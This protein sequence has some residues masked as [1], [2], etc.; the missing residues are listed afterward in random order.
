MHSVYLIA[1]REVTTRLSS[2]SFIAGTLVTVA[3]LVACIIGSTFL[4][5]GDDPTAMAPEFAKQTA[6]ASDQAFNEVMQ[7]HGLVPEQI[8]A[9]VATATTD[10]LAKLQ[11]SQG[12]DASMIGYFLGIGVAVLLFVALQITGQMIAQGIV[13]EKGS[14]VVEILLGTVS[15]FQLLLGK[16]LGVGI[17]GILQ[18][19][20]I[21][22]SA[23]G[24][25]RAVSIDVLAGMNISEIAL[26]LVPCFLVAY[27]AYATLYAALASTV[28][29]Q[30]EVPQVITPVMILMMISYIGVMI[31][32]IAANSVVKFV[33][34]Y[35]PLASNISMPS[36]FASGNIQ[37]WECLVSLGVSA[38][39]LPVIVWIAS[40]I[41]SRSI[42][43]SGPKVKWVKALLAKG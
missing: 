9:E 7:K 40:R 30:E 15:S 33:L 38:L 43:Q 25:A 17:V 20:V 11:D 34:T 31:P 1:K 13:E 2:K 14:R 19:A 35:V 22:G 36:L 10:A 29:R 21:V 39:S 23:Y 18:V 41:Y 32:G 37:M 27:F 5:S 42:L 24:A 4:P 16:I 3:I 8:K 12:S 28:S 6:L 26:I